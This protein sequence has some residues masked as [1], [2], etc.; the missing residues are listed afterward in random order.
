MNITSAPPF[1]ARDT[2][3]LIIW[4]DICN[5]QEAVLPSELTV[6]IYHD[7]LRSRSVRQK[8]GLTMVGKYCEGS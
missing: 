8:S 5:F 3:P 6:E 4:S 7:P 2:Q 1:S